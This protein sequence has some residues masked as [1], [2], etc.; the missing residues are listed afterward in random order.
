MKEAKNT[1]G[2]VSKVALKLAER[3]RQTGRRSPQELIPLIDEAEQLASGTSDPFTQAVCVRATGNAHQMLNNF[4][5]ALDRYDSAI[6]LFEGVGES[7][8]IG[9]TLLAK[10]G[11]LFYLSRFDELFECARNAR[12]LFEEAGEDASLARL[13]VN[14]G[15]AYHRLDRYHEAMACYDR[16][17]PILE[18]TGDREGLLASSLN[19]GVVLTA[20]HDFDRAEDS[21]DTAMRLAAEL[22]MQAIELQSRYNRTYLD[23]LK[24]NSGRALGDMF[25]LKQDFRNR[26]DDRHVGLCWLDEAEML[27]EIGHL[28]EAISSAQESREFAKK[29]GLNYELGKSLL[30]EA[31]AS[32]RLGNSD[33]AAD[34]L[35][36]ASRRFESEG[37][38]VWTAVSRLQTALFRG[39]AGHAS[40]LAEAAA[41]RR[42][43]NDL[44]LPDRLAMAD[45]VI[46]RIQ[47]SS[48]DNECAI[49]SFRSAV[50]LADESH[51]DWMQFHANHELGVSLSEVDEGDSVRYLR[52]AESMLD[53]LWHRIGSDDL[54]MAFLTDRENV[55]THLVDKVAVDSIPEAFRLS[56]RAR[57]RV[58]VERLSGAEQALE[59]EGIEELV[60]TGETLVEYFIA[61][62]DLYIFTVNAGSLD[63]VHRKGVVHSLQEEWTHL[64]RHLA[65]CAVKWERL[66]KMRHH[67]LY[68]ANEHLRRLW[69]GLIEPV[70]DNLA[71]RVVIVP[72]GFLHAIPFQSLH[73]GEAFLCENHSI[74]YSPSATLYTS[75]TPPAGEEE[76]P[77]PPLFVAFSTND[78]EQ[79]TAEVRRAAARFDD[80]VVLVN[81]TLYQ[82]SDHLSQ[83]RELVHVA[84]HAGVDPVQG[85]LSWLETSEG[86]LTSRD[87]MD[88]KFRAGTVVVTGCHTARRTISAGDEWLG[89]MRAFYLS[90][91]HTIVSA[92]WAIRDA[93]AQ[94]FSESFYEH[95]DG[96]N[97]PKAVQA[98]T[99]AIRDSNPHPYFWG[100][101][102]AFVRKR[103]GSRYE[104]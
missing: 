81:P 25:A 57:S 2:A 65:S 88:M 41:A 67:L 58:L 84:G 93:S 71:E 100:G 54:K 101:F 40:A 76:D 13:D 73:D 4:S 5:A 50:R 89:L 92:F 17:F 82:L 99:G 66:E 26:D 48:G 68:T 23:Y 85:G 96:T 47:R 24:G 29:L 55:Y 10:V 56:E 22:D 70:Q 95:Y 36:D 44:A 42:L 77:A 39:E 18:E 74:A 94:S 63:C 53:S 37:N 64:E 9:R 3:I 104:P 78:K 60:P 32:L 49:D 80:A 86:R 11:L 98:A 34:L 33:D 14:L 8:Q 16:A 28:S 51:S 75:Y 59:E 12:R 103:G 19:A 90:G 87:L 20:L 61:G 43:L 35:A 52:R 30:F 27:L 102:G 46:G 69:E 79:I 31:V 1:E 21:Y 97:A 62:D 38:S 7:A 6:V 72:H 91:A 15:N 45:V 83:Y